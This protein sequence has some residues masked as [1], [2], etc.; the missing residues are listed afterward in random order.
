MYLHLPRIAEHWRGLRTRSARGKIRKVNTMRW[1]RPG[2]GE[3][4]ARAGVR[5]GQAMEVL[6]SYSGWVGPPSADLE[7]GAGRFLTY[8]WRSLCL[9]WKTDQMLRV[10]IGQSVK[11]SLSDPSEKHAQMTVAE[12][13]GRGFSLVGSDYQLWDSRSAWLVDEEEEQIAPK[14]RRVNWRE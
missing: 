8:V 12:M 9:V 3:L 7:K 6:P 10:E 5:V 13:L 11:H 14:L 4:E 1:E 2:V